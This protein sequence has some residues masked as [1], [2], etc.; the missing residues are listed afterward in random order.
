M[1]KFN[2]NE[3][4]NRVDVFPGQTFEI[5]AVAVGQRFGISIRAEM[6]I[7]IV[8]QLQKLQ[9]TES[10]YTKLKFTTWSSNRN[11]TMLQNIDGQIM[12]KWINETIPD[13]L[14][15]FTSAITNT[16]I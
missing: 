8:D 11:K 7:N 12:P 13:E 2:T 1:H 10:H 9:D 5:E 4:E 3:T 16:A 14:L 15:Q 6:G